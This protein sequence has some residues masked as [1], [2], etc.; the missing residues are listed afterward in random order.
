MWP[1]KYEPSSKAR[2]PI[3]PIVCW[4]TVKHFPGHGDT[5][6]DSHM[7][8]P[9]S[10]A[11]GPDAVAWSLFHFEKAFRAGVDAVMTAHMAVPAYETED[12]PATVSTKCLRVL[13]ATRFISPDL[14]SRTQWTCK[15]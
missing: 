9:R 5:D 7:G 2:I 8:L 15:A 10:E 13:L 6:V 1:R 11:T 12:I 14:L 3:L 4:L